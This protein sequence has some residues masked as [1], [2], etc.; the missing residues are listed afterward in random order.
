MRRA[1]F[2][3]LMSAFMLV[4]TG[5]SAVDSSSPDVE[6]STEELQSEAIE[7]KVEEEVKVEIVSP[8]IPR[9]H[10]YNSIEINFIDAIKDTNMDIVLDHVLVDKLAIETAIEKGLL[11]M[12]NYSNG[13]LTFLLKSNS[14]FKAIFNPANTDSV[15]GWE[16]FKANFPFEVQAN[17]DAN[18]R[19]TQFNL[20]LDYTSEVVGSELETLDFD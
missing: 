10:G 16:H 1:K 11:R 17:A 2:I 18:N 19:L 5:C 14:V 8:D 13:R 20:R 3:I 7:E 4:I 15:E 9:Q 6:E 12:Y